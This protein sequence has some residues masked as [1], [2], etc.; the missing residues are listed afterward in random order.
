M[1]QPP[2]NNAKIHLD[3]PC[4]CAFPDASSWDLC[5][6]LFSRCYQ[7]NFL[8]KFQEHVMLITERLYMILPQSI[9]GKIS[10]YQL[11]LISP[12]PKIKLKPTFPN[13]MKLIEWI[14]EYDFYLNDLIDEI[15]RIQKRIIELK[16]KLISTN[17]KVFPSI[18]NQKHIQKM[19]NL[20]SNFVVTRKN[21]QQEDSN[22]NSIICT[23]KS[24]KERIT[25]D[26]IQNLPKDLKSNGIKD[27]AISEQES[28]ELFNS[29]MNGEFGQED[30]DHDECDCDC[31]FHGPSNADMF[32]W[33]SSFSPAT[34]NRL[35]PDKLFDKFMQ[36]KNANDR[37]I[38]PTHPK[39]PS[40]TKGSGKS[41][42]S[43]SSKSKFPSVNSVR[44]EK[45]KKSIKVGSSGMSKE[46]KEQLI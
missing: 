12:P 26:K 14:H 5:V 43:S 46:E 10:L 42:S 22:S 3:Q 25:I 34:L 45:P 15:Q 7:A 16:N 2:T 31:G 41:S 1:T 36:M 40:S 19:E 20:T 23:Y 37:P 13:N 6:M 9:K 39:H 38:T 32:S 27:N 17:K 35:G 33:L 18:S 11:P 8:E 44:N 28:K 29:Y 30:G 21:I 24:K 4:P